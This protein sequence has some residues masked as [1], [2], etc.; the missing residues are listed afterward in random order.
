MSGMSREEVVS[1]RRLYQEDSDEYYDLFDSNRE[2]ISQYDRRLGK[3]FL[4][5]SEVAEQLSPY[6]TSTYHH[7]AVKLGGEFVGATSFIL[8]R[9]RS[10]EIATW[11]DRDHVQKGLAT[12]A[13]R[14]LINHGFMWEGIRKFDAL[15]TP[16]NEPSKR[17]VQ[18]LGFIHTETLEEDE[19][20]S[21]TRPTNI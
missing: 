4:S 8:K 14:M 15:I 17:T 18:R 12:R 7:Y 5:L 21:L 11:I 3:A 16:D 9:D 20:Y 13:T 10:A 6:N 1:L 19:V 2:H